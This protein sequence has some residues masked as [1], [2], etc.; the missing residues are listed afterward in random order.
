[1]MA[2]APGPTQSAGPRPSAAL[3]RRHRARLSRVV[4]ASVRRRHHNVFYSRFVGLM[5]IVLPAT[6]VALAALVL[7]WPQINPL[8][9]RFRLKP[10]QVTIDDL[11]NLR[12]VQPRFVGTD[13][14]NQ[15]FTITADQATQEAG[16]SD[17]TALASPKGDLTLNNGSWIALAASEGVY[18][19]QTRLLELW[20]EVNVFHDAGYEIKT[21]RA[22]ADLGEG[23]V[24]GD[25]PVEGQG[26]DSHLRGEGFRIYDKGARIAV[27]GKSRLV[28]YPNPPE[29][30]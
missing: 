24:F 22:K 2:V 4:S 3:P 23:N 13:A 18:H 20:D 28:L 21:R 12:M 30:K 27:T 15:P 10:V 7:F 17:T 1:M 11:E 29:K 9:N 16:A 14:K 26:P 8:D 6:A 5:K 19:K 25:D